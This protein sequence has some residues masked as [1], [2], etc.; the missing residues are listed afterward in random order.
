MSLPTFTIP[1]IAMF[2]LDKGGMIPKARIPK[3]ALELLVV[4]FALWTAPP[5]SCSLFPQKGEISAME[6]EEEFRGKRNSNG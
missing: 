1:G 5:L 2:M 4:S 6:I 3:T